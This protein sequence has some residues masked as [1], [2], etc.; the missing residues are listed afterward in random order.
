MLRSLG[1]SVNQLDLT[2]LNQGDLDIRLGDAD[3]VYVHG[4]N[5]FYLLQEMQRTGFKNSIQRFIAHGGLYIGSSAGAIVAGPRIDIVAATDDPSQAPLVDA[6]TALSL[7]PIIPFVHFDVAH[8]RA[9]FTE[10][11]AL[12]MDGALNLL[13][14]RN[15]QCLLVEGEEFSLW[16]V[17][18]GA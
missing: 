5:T 13:P 16:T 4:G 14:L 18:A 11:F 9:A 8:Y 10:A 12:A 7:I 3:G 17:P 2:N 15:D 6:H 1:C